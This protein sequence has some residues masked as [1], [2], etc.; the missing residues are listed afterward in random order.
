[1]TEILCVLKSIDHKYSSMKF[2]K[3]LLLT[4]LSM[5][6]LFF[7]WFSLLL[8]EIY[9]NFFWLVMNYR[10]TKYVSLLFFSFWGT[11]V[12]SLQVDSL[13]CLL[14]AR[15]TPVGSNTWRLVVCGGDCTRSFDFEERA[16]THVNE[17]WCLKTRCV[18][19]QS[20]LVFRLWGESLY[21]C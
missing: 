7:S 15:V 16:L 2:L 9:M 12:V 18:R 3:L 17:V 20:P 1:L 10:S 5:H 13:L 6:C 14:C 11:M 8:K 21:I 4:Y 19:W